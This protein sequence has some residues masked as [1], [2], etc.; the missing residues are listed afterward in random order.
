MRVSKLFTKTTR[1]ISKEAESKNHELLVRGGYVDQLMAGVYTYLPLGFKVLKNIENIVREEMLNI[2]GQEI[3]MPTLHPKDNWMK[4]GRWDTMDDLY[5]FTSYYSKNEVALG[6]THEEIV[7][8]LAKKFVFSYKDLPKYVFQIQTKFRDEKRAKSGILRGR[9]FRMKDLYSFHV[10]EDDLESYYQKVINSYKKIFK[11]LGLEKIT[12]LTYSPGGTFS[13]FSHEF[14]TESLVGEDTVFL[15]EKC[16]VAVNKEI[17]D[18][19]K[20]CPECD[21]RELKETKTI[22][23]G[24]I[25]KLK[26]KFSDP[27]NLKYLDKD[28][29]EKPVVMGCY[30]IGPSRMMGTIVET[31][32]DEKGI[33]WPKEVTPYH[34]HIVDLRMVGEAERL[35]KTLEA[36][37]I[38]V[39]W[40]DRDESAGVKFADSDILGVPI[41]IVV[42]DKSQKSGGYEL[43]L[44]DKEDTEIVKEKDLIKRIKE[45]YAK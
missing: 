31:L 24:N 42:S 18:V 5:R 36:E 2:D 41:R 17:I 21:N 4:T 28:G 20:S 10:D 9:E 30:G 29:K 11:R 34:V 16:K 14:Q 45:Y 19:Q 7:S 27:F 44:R 35:V 15:C 25:F 8:P 12:Y 26:T 3:L 38:D 6:A 33:I 43:K 13:K 37:G 32:S 22:E 39:L 1:N 40:D 23:V